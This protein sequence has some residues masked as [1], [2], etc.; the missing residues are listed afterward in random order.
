[1]SKTNKL[2]KPNKPRN[3]IVRNMIDNPNRN[4]GRHRDK[5][6]DAEYREVSHLLRRLR[7][8]ERMIKVWND[9]FK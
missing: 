7:R 9:N 8:D 2:G 5:V 4:A 6:R 3:M 1:M